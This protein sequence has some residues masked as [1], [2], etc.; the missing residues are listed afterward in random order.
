MRADSGDT[1]VL[2]SYEEVIADKRAFVAMTR[3]IHRRDQSVQRPAAGAI[4]RPR[5]GGGQSAGLAA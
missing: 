4:S 1:I 5:G 2:P 3:A